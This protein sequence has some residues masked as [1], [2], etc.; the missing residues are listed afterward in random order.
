MFVRPSDA[1]K[2]SRPCLGSLRECVIPIL[3]LLFSLSDKHKGPCVGKELELDA[4]GLTLK[5]KINA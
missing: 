4:T 3:T 1:L 5:K 2:Y